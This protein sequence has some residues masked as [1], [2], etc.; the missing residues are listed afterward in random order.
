MIYISIMGFEPYHGL[1]RSRERRH[2]IVNFSLVRSA[3]GIYCIDDIDKLRIGQMACQ[4][5]HRVVPCVHSLCYWS[6]IFVITL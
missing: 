4:L 3:T 2:S 5:V 6:G 1:E